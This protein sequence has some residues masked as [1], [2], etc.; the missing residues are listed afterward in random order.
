MS[1]HIK[2]RHVTLTSLA[3]ESWVKNDLQN[4]RLKVSSH[5]KFAPNKQLVHEELLNLPKSMYMLTPVRK[6]CLRHITQLTLS[7]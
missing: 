6:N 7:V 2:S 5:L 4:L 1:R 3:F